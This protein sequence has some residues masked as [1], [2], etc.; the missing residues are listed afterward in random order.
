MNDYTLPTGTPMGGISTDYGTDGMNFD[1][2]GMSA[3]NA[4]AY[5]WEMIGLGLD[6]PLPP[7]ETIDDLYVLCKA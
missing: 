1:Q 3:E 6:E 7:Q 4:D 2:P 5:P